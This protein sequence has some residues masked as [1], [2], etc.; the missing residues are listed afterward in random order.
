MPKSQ[1]S[2][3]ATMG[4]F[5]ICKKTCTRRTNVEILW[6]SI[7]HSPTPHQ[8]SIAFYFMFG[9]FHVMNGL[10][11]GGTHWQPSEALKRFTS[12]KGNLQYTMTY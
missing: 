11:M 7:N 5:D 2:T 12:Q 8:T 3:S 10:A 6:P 4:P 9:Y 1:F